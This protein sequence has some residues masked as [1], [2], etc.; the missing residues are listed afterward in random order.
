MQNLVD[1]AAF[2]CCLHKFTLFAGETKHSTVRK[3]PDR[4]AACAF[5]FRRSFNC[6]R[7]AMNRLSGYRDIIIAQP[8]EVIDFEV[9]D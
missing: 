6:T 9:D 8:E 5:Y 3:G 4:Q 7:P 1:T 2:R